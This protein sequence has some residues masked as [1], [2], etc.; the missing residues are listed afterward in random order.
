MSPWT[1]EEEAAVRRKLDW[2]VVP[3][4]TVLYMLC[5]LDRA[6]IGNARIQGMGTELNLV[7]YRFNWALSVFYIVY[8]MIEVPSNI[9]LKRVGPRFYI[10]GLVVGFGF[11]S[12]CTAFVQTFEQLCGL[13]ALLG[14]FEGGT[15]PGIAF[16]LS[17]FYKREELLF[18][19]GIY[20]AS[21][22]M[23]GAFGGLLATGLSRIPPWGIAA[24]PVTT[25]R[26]IFF[27]EGIITMIA[28]LLAPIFLPQ[29]PGVSTRLTERERWIAD[30]RLRLEHKM[31]SDEQVKLR[32]VKRA[33]MNINNYVCA[34]G[35]FLIN[36]TVQGLSVF[37]PTVLADLGWTATKAQLYSV[38][39]YVMA[40]VVAI[41]IAFVSDKTRM[42]GLWL[43][44]FTL[45]AI[46]GFSILRWSHNPSLKYMGVFFCTVGAFPGGPGFLSWG[47]N[48]A[49]GPAVRAVSGGWIVTIGTLGGV[50][51]TW[52]YLARD[53]PDYP[54][55]NS[56]NLGGQ[57]LTLFLTLFGIFY[58]MWENRLRE[59]GGRDYRLEGLTEEEQAGLGYRHPQFRYIL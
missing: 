52:T 39:P 58:C 1:V 43:A 19:V 41:G 9:I 50:L 34:G 27:F 20:V 40:S 36:I 54:I 18:R 49:S 48:N 35:F 22:S 32:H 45:I 12:M 31:I 3:T 17:S 24:A 47:L 44:L 16:F 33:V 30:E 28:G 38:P 6:N 15:M 21:A 2:Q 37:M 59:R 55:G 4:V 11:V 57:I 23:A 26:N 51:A 7:G 25:W 53:G 10:P 29:S 5:F 42:R 8:V 14:V 13:R 46:T 56:I